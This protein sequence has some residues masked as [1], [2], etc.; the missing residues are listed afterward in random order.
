MSIQPPVG[1]LELEERQKKLDAML[2]DFVKKGGVIE[3]IPYGMTGEMY[4]ENLKGTIKKK[5]KKK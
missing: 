2:K 3:K 4:R 5:R 1:P